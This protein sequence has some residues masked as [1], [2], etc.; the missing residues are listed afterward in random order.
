MTCEEQKRLKEI[1]EA[2][3]SAAYEIMKESF[4]PDERRSEG[5]QRAL[6][7][8]DSYRLLGLFVGNKLT[9]LAAVYMLKDFVFIE[10]LAT[11]KSFRN[12]GLGAEMLLVVKEKYGKRLVLEVELP[13]GETEQRRI[14]FYSRNGFYYNDYFYI[15]PPLEEGKKEVELR[16][17]TTE[18]PLVEKKFQELK[19]EIYFVVYNLNK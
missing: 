1:T 15:Q 11:D 16:L 7:K 12:R 9:T 4:P 19:N 10:H 2:E 14:N 18:K 8:K 3:F 13:I 17:M 5:G 6:I